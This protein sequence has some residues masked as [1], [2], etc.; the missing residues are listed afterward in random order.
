VLLVMK[1][2]T[3]DVLVLT[4]SFL[5]SHCFP[6]LRQMFKISNF[7]TAPAS[8]PTSLFVLSSKKIYKIVLP[9]ERNI[10]L[11]DN[12]SPVTLTQVLKLNA[13]ISMEMDFLNHSVCVL[14]NF[15]INCYNA[16]DI[17]HKKWK[18]PQP[19]FLPTFECRFFINL[20]LNNA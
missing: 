3:I 17:L 16:S 18:L 6:F 13:P 10:S 9:S 12:Q 7:S 1:E 8:D 20:N 2:S 15:E 11:S 19:D 5:S 4:V 14:E